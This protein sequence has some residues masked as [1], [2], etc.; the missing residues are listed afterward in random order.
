MKIKNIL[1]DHGRGLCFLLAIIIA[2]ILSERTIATPIPPAE[3]GQGYAMRGF[4]LYGYLHSGQW[5]H[6]W[7]LLNHPNQSIC[8]LHYLLFFILPQ[9]LA[10]MA[11]YVLSQNL[12]IY[13]LL[14]AATFKLCQALSRAEWAPAIFLLCAVNNLAQTDYFFF[15]LD[16]EFFSAGLFAVAWQLMAWREERPSKSILSGMALG[17]PFWIKPANAL[18]FIAVF[19]LSEIFRATGNFLACKSTADRRRSL[20]ASARHWGCQVLGFAPLLGL[21][22]YCGGTQS[23]LQLIQGNEI[24]N[25][26][27]PLHCEFLLRLFY[28]PLCF[29]FFYHALLLGGLLSAVFFFGKKKLL[30]NPEKNLFPVDLYLPLALAYLV[31]GG[32]FS[33]GMQTKA[34]RSLLPML[35]LFWIALFWLIERRRLRTDLMFLV[36]GIYAVTVFSQKAL[37]ILGT[38]SSYIDDTYQLTLRSW[39][40]MPSPWRGGSINKAIADGLGQ[41]PPPPGILCV[42][43]IELQKDLAWRL[44]SSDLLLG[45][46]PRYDVHI[47][48]TF[49]GTY[50]NRT[51][52]GAHMIIFETWGVKS[53][54]RTNDESLDMLQYGIDEWVTKKKWAQPGELTDAGGEPIGYLFLFPAP[55]TQAQVDLTNKSEPFSRMPQQEDDGSVSVSGHHFTRAEAWDLIKVWYDKRISHLF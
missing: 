54:T 32:F 46:P 42:N 23:I 36:A 24:N 33:F 31:W 16:M 41:N 20:V 10:G 11:A 28:F 35:P 26:T 3:D 45:R 18:I 14:A 13:L 21:A 44:N 6:F 30:K 12:V 7:T 25:T 2:L 4:T 52:V 39:I 17:L 47:I 9:A 43:S 5:S 38:K 48:F 50:L 27:T 34:I 49:N 22:F 55:L 51:F 40:Q 19:V 15:Y 8:P 37:D 1:L 29:S 53:N